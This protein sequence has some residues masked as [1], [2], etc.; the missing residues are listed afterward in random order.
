MLSLLN[1]SNIALS[2][3]LN[4]EFGRSLNLLTGETGSGKSIIVDAGYPDRRKVHF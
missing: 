2:D 1:T 3:E 4:V